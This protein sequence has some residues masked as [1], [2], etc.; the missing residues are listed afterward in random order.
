MKIETWTV[1]VFKF[2][3]ANGYQPTGEILLFQANEINALEY[4]K[5]WN[6][7]RKQEGEKT[8]FPMTEGTL[9]AMCVPDIDG[10]NNG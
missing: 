10:M 7:K 5:A 6:L 2:T 9:Y 3:G 8:G 4:A 1:K